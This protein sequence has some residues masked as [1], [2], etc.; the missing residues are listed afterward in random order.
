[1]KSKP[2]LGREALPAG[3]IEA[4]SYCIRTLRSVR[5]FLP[6]EVDQTCIDFVL[7]H[8][9]Q[10]GSAKNRQPWRFVVVR[11]RNTMSALGDWYRRGWST[12]SARIRRFPDAIAASDEHQ[13][14]MSDGAVLAE[15]FD[16]APLVV[17]AC[18]VPIPRNPAD[19]Y[20]G[21]S[22]YPAIQNLLLAARALGL[23]ATLTTV[24]CLDT[25]H[26]ADHPSLSGELRA[27]LGI[28]EDVVPAAV[29]PLGWPATTFGETR[30][31]PAPA[32]TYAERWGNPWVSDA[33]MIL[34]GDRDG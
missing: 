8:A 3:D 23:G 26:D 6:T 24:Q 14:Q 33:H 16:T 1:M 11:D 28:P 5:R 7:E 12:I 2:I 17:V 30:R 21:A 15:Q 9:V 18:F 31:L 29:I 27:I 32:V 20:G 19:F 34:A 13:R 25:Q 10:A 4:V 22:I